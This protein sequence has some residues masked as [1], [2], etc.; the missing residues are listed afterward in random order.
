MKDQAREQCPLIKLGGN[1]GSY[2][3]EGRISLSRS[4][5]YYGRGGGEYFSHFTGVCRWL[6]CKKEES[7][8]ANT[9]AAATA[10]S[11]PSCVITACHNSHK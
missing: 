7:M 1:T 5:S 11:A 9:G 10:V 4:V 6:G 2:I 8:Q 3:F